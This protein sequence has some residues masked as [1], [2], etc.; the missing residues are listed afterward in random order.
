M[1][2]HVYHVG[3]C[4]LFQY[5]YYDIPFTIYCLRFT[6]HSLIFAMYVFPTICLFTIHLLALRLLFP[7]SYLHCSPARPRSPSPS[8]KKEVSVRLARL[9]G[10]LGGVVATLS[11]L[12][13]VVAHRHTVGGLGRPARDRQNTL[14]STITDLPCIVAL[15]VCYE[16][17]LFTYYSYVRCASSYLLFPVCYLLLTLYDVYDFLVY[18][19]CTIFP[20]TIYYRQIV[21]WGVRFCSSVCGWLSP[22]Y[23]V[24]FEFLFHYL[25]FTICY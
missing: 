16:R 3:C 7:I 20:F 4:C 22:T 17:L 19:R 11:H 2:F 21:F 15:T 9:V 12:L 5:Y 13:K 6:M 18:L 1:C 10:Q 25:C 14:A 24:V 8:K 23:Y